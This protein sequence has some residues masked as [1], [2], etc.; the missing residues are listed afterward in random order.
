MKTPYD[1]AQRIA[2]RRLDAVRAEMAK[3]AAQLRLIELEEDNAAA[4]LQRETLLACDDARMTTERYFVQAREYRS[5]LIAMRAATHAE[6][7][8]LRHKAVAFYGERI[9]IDTAVSSYR[10]EAERAAA[11]A[12]QAALDDLTGGRHRRPTRRIARGAGQTMLLEPP[13]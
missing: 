3:A 12:E 11:S 4:A 5:R 10:E 13:R 9:A 6:L 7:E 8:S 1:T 2:E